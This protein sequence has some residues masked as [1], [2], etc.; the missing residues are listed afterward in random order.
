M[1]DVLSCPM[2]RATL[3]F[4]CG[5]DGLETIQELVAS[6]RS[7]SQIKIQNNP[8]EKQNVVLELE[9]Q[10][11]FL[12]HFVHLSFSLSTRPW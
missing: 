2:P 12:N 4:I 11:L 6:W 10:I 8:N 3:V 9:W 7:E 1:L 5:S